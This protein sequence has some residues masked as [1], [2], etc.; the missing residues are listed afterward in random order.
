MTTTKAVL[1]SDEELDKDSD[2]EVFAMGEDLDT[3][4]QN[5]K[6]EHQASPSKPERLEDSPFHGSDA[7][8]SYSSSDSSTSISEYLRKYDDVVPL[9]E[10]QFVKFLRKSNTALFNEI[11]KKQWK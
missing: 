11:T 4:A 7:L 2:E 3:D 9:T 1:L 5:T 10:R 8:A 6:H